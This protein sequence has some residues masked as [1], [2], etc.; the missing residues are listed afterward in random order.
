MA[1]AGAGIDP[2]SAVSSF[3]VDRVDPSHFEPLT[4]ERFTVRQATGDRRVRVHLARVHQ[5]W[6]TEKVQQFSL[7]FHGST[8]DPLAQGLHEFRHPALGSFS[9]F[10]SPIGLPGGERCA[11]Q[12]C[13]SR[14]VRS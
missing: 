6:S 13:F 10:I 4:G 11:Y 8:S 7:I 9:I 12:A 1:T 14:H 3:Q 2:A 5:Q